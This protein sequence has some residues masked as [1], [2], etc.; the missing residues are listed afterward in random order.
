MR[1]YCVMRK[2]FYKMHGVG[3]DYVY[4]NCM[5]QAIANPQAL[6]RRIS[7]RQFSVG[8]DGVILILKSK[9]ADAKMRIFNADGSEGKMCGNGIRCVAKFLF[10]HKIVSKE[11]LTVE[12]LSGVKTLWITQTQNGLAEQIKADMGRAEFSPKAIPVALSGEAII[13]RSVCVGGKNYAITCVSMGNP[14]CVVFD[15]PEEPFETIGRAFEQSPL[16]PEGVNVEFAQ[17]VDE[18]TLSLRVWERG[19]GET[20]SCGTGAC[21]AVAAAVQN[22]LLP[23]G[24]PITV[25]LKGGELTVQYTKESVYMTGPAVLAYT[26]VVEI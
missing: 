3:N 2:K 5:H 6:A 18:N 24:Q 8:A 19:S 23:M 1:I 26:G 16:F 25:R 7:H 12:T 11:I 9:I 14:H 17:I 22:R 10:D 20:M 4:F 15:A 13:N 21:A